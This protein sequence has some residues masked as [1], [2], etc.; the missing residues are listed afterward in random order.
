MSEDSNTVEDSA[1]G[2]RPE[3]FCALTLNN[4]TN[5][6]GV[7]SY[8]SYTNVLGFTEIFAFDGDL[9]DV[10][11]RVQSHVLATTV[12]V[13][14]DLDKAILD[15]IRDHHATLQQST[16]FG[17]IGELELSVQRPIAFNFKKVTKPASEKFLPRTALVVVLNIIASL[18]IGLDD[19]GERKNSA[20][21][22]KLW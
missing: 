10:L 2:V 1:E 8:N 13:A 18:F 5:K 3:V 21:Y 17:N 14:D 9:G 19:F 7:A 6:L 15:I 12:I 11:F 20:E 16:E 4:T 22:C